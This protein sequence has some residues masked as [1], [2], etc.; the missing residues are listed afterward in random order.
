LRDIVEDLATMNTALVAITPQICDKSREMVDKHK[1]NFPLLRDEGN[2]YMDQLGLRFVV[3]DDVLEVY[4]GFGIDL[5]KA[6]G[7]SSNSLPIP[8]RLVVGS[9]GVVKIADID[10]N[11]TA[12]PEPDKTLVD[13]R[14]LLA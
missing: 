1:L 13:V 4:G 12:R 10:P 3:P 11:Y 8:C 7:E 6:N 5:P 9:D 2:A 14:A